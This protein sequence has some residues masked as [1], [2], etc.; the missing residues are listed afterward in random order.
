MSTVSANDEIPFALVH[1]VPISVP[2]T[3]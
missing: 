1:Y 3:S 2:F